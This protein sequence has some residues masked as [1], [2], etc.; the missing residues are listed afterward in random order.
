LYEAGLGVDQ[1]QLK[2][3][4]LYRQAWGLPATA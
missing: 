3:L 4:N 2:A 1:D